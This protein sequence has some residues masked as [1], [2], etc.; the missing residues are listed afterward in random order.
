MFTWSLAW[1]S[2]PARL[3]ITSLAFMFDEV[4]E[5][6][7]KTSIGNWS[8]CSPAADLVARGGDPLGHVG[9]EQPELGVGARGRGLDAAEHADHGDRNA[10]A[11]DR[12]VLHRLARLRAPELLLDRHL[13][14]SLSTFGACSLTTAS[15]RRA[16]PAARARNAGGAVSS[17]QRL[18]LEPAH[19][20]VVH[21]LVA[22]ARCAAPRP[23]GSR[24]GWPPRR[25]GAP[26]PRPWT[27]PRRP[28]GRPLPTSRSSPPSLSSSRHSDSGVP[29]SRTS[30]GA[31]LSA[32]AHRALALAARGRH[33]GLAPRGRMR[34][35]RPETRRRPAQESLR[36]AH[37]AILR[38]ARAPFAPLCAANPLQFS[39]RRGRDLGD[40]CSAGSAWPP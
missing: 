21:P 35:L 33:A 28:P 37:R 31:A 8:S 17:A 6:V 5:P 10:L 12:E 38:R 20:L 29:S 15:R 3:A 25:P 16:P 1:A 32:S 18:L 26:R 11:G 36:A 13:S 2:S 30:P 22:P 19:Q 27:G 39:T 40:P 4:P 24:A 7:W 9:V 34:R 14:P 23:S